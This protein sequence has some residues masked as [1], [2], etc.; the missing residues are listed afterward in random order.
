MQMSE[1]TE[2]QQ[3]ARLESMYKSMVQVWQTSEQCTE[4]GRF[5]QETILPLKKLELNKAW[6]IGLGSLVVDPIRTS[7]QQSDYS[8][9]LNSIC[10]FVAFEHWL[11]LLQKNGQRFSKG[12]FFQDPAF[13][14]ADH[15][16][17]TSKG[18]GVIAA[19]G[20]AEYSCSSETFLFSVIGSIRQV[21]Y[22][23]LSN[24]HPSL[25]IGHMISCEDTHFFSP[26]PSGGWEI[27]SDPAPLASMRPV[28]YR[29]EEV[30][31]RRVNRPFYS[32]TLQRPLF[33]ETAWPSQY[34]SIYPQVG[35]LAPPG[36]QWLWEMRVYWKPDNKER[37]SEVRVE[38][39][40]QCQ[41]CRCRQA[42]AIPAHSEM[43]W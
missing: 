3:I 9:A 15:T 2:L 24:V 38:D 25:V 14:S 29:S 4:S 42:M 41:C 8:L 21:I 26:I 19:K 17:I 22:D 39:E 20:S 28:Q 37:C 31:R 5:F 33:L 12:I 35:K 40:M 34:L 1:E 18:Y 27:V 30:K 43:G 23:I 36:L 7:S 32:A 13:T 6:C 16:F 11:E 10:Q